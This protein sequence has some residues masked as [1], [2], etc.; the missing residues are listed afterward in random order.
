MP[1][2]FAGILGL[3]PSPGSLRLATPPA[4]PLQVV[5]EVHGT[6]TQV[7]PQQRGVGGEDCSHRQPPG[8][9]QAE[10]DARQ[11]FVEVCDHMRLLLTLGQ[12]LRSNRNGATVPR[13][14][15]KQGDR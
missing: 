15:R 6:G 8:A 7:S 3:F 1:S 5:V 14:T 12:E 9:A 2:G 13:W 11:P 10:P 4:H